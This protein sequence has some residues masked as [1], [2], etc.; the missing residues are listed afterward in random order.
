MS[1]LSASISLFGKGHFKSARAQQSVHLTLGILRTSQA[2]SHALSFFWLD[3]FAVPAPAQVTQT[4]SFL[5]I[6]KMVLFN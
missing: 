4:V 3:G 1:R 5:F 6:I 2:V